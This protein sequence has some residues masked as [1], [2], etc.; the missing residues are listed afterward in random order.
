VDGSEMNL[1]KAIRVPTGKQKIVFQYLGLSLAKPERVRYRYWLDGFDRGWSEATT[2]R[3][4]VFA[5]LSPGQ[6]RF[7]V[8]CSN[9][10]GIWNN[11]DASIDFSVLPAFYETNWF[12]M[13]CVTAFLASLWGIYQLRVQQLQ[14]QFNVALDAR[15]NERT[16]IARELH[17]TLLQTL[18]GLMFRFQAAR[19]MFAGR[20]EEALEALDG[21]IGRTEQ[22]IAES[23]E[24]IKNLRIE[25]STSTDLDE[26]LNAAGQELETPFDVRPNRPTFQSFVSGERQTLCPGIKDEVYRIGRELLRNAFQHAQAHHIEAEIRYDDHALI[27]L[28]RDDGKGLDPTVIKQGGRA[29]HWGLPGIRERAKQIQGHLDFWTESRAGTEVQ[30]TVPG[31][32]A[33]KTSANKSLFRLFRGKKFHEP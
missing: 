20:P 6:Y 9:S 13:L 14:R 18:H 31:M 28:V 1:G 5:N 16:R 25:H 22:A 26:L 2:N 32:V 7:R 8:I 21:A 19:N 4:A 12:R 24:A 33:Y 15:V 30:L 27:L 23:R 17:D 3:E 10:D 29:G 11:A